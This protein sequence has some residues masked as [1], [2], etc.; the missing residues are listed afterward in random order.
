MPNVIET[1]KKSQKKFKWGGGQDGKWSQFFPGFFLDQ[2]G[3][4]VTQMLKKQMQM[5]NT[6]TTH[7]NSF[8]FIQVH[9]II[10]KMLWLVRGAGNR[11]MLTL[12]DKEEG[13]E[14]KASLHL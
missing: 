10:I 4:A 5:Q 6:L 2:E 14:G 12:A 9:S 7:F 8:K 3:T 13:G 1:N 11:Q